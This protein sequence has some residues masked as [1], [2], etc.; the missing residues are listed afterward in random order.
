MV[1]VFNTWYHLYLAGFE[2]PTDSLVACCP[3]RNSVCSVQGVVAVSIAERLTFTKRVGA[4][5]QTSE[6]AVLIWNFSDPIH[7][8]LVL[9][10]PFE[11]VAFA[12][13]PETPDIVVGGCYNGQVVLWDLS[14][15]RELIAAT[16]TTA[17]KEEESKEVTVEHR[18]LSTIEYSHRGPVTDLKWL[19]G[20]EVTGKGSL[21]DCAE[22]RGMCA[23]FATCAGDGKVRPLAL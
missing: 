11:V 4:F 6:F 13:N 23:F 14:E 19:P 10:S 15:Q 5:G 7:P 17:D 1:C 9:E 22:S 20:M 3:C 16:R 18:H 21:V 2:S 8:E 12:L